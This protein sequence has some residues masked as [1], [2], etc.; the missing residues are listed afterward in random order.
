M[1]MYSDVDHSIFLRKISLLT[2]CLLYPARIACWSFVMSMPLGCVLL[3]DVSSWGLAWCWF[4]WWWALLNSCMLDGDAASFKEPM[5]GVGT[6]MG[7]LPLHLA[8][9]I[10]ISF[11]TS[12][13]TSGPKQF[14]YT[15]WYYNIIILYIAIHS[16]K[17]RRA[18]QN[19]EKALVFSVNIVYPVYIL[20]II[21]SNNTYF[22]YC[23]VFE[24]EKL[25]HFEDNI[26]YIVYYAAQIWKKKI[27]I[28]NDD[29]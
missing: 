15:W 12:F 21:N 17:N 25:C 16:L 5:L 22:R 19:S 3:N 8:V 18:Y 6:L 24:L 23:S 14:S 4:C 27:V 20:Y 26:N 1:C 13:T 9:A 29:F 28:Y 7:M 10:F 11:R 2:R